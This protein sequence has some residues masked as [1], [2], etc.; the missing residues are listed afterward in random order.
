[1]GTE[2]TIVAA[3]CAA[4]VLAMAGTMSF[5]AL[6]PTFITEWQLSHSE[7]GWISGI[8]YGAYVAGVPILVSLTDR[9]DARRIVIVFSLLAAVSNIGFALFAEGF[10]SALFFR[11]LGGLALGGTYMPGLKALTD[12]VEGPYKARYQSFYT[13]SFSVG[14]SASLFI[15][16]VLAAQYDWPLAFVVAGVAPLLAVVVLLRWVPPVAPAP[17]EEKPEALLD[18]RPVLRQRESMSYVL[19]YAAHC[20]ELFAFRTWLVAFMTFNAVAHGSAI[21]ES[22]IATAAS[23]ILLLGLPASVLGNEVAT[24]LGRRGVLIGF[25]LASTLVASMIGFAA[26]LPFWWMTVLLAVYGVTVM[27]DSASLTIGALGAAA[28]ERRG[29]T[30]AV[31]TTLGTSMAFLGP[32]ASGFALDLTGGGATVLSWVTCFLVLAAGVALG[33]LALWGLGGR[34]APLSRQRETA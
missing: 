11:G 8:T 18:F 10:W 17:R 33:P 14:S 19:G 9:I 12:R 26:A 3:L 24:R 4:E 7:V 31:H 29:S 13:A 20:W 16:G 27:L 1:M 5:Q 22:T 21:G 2:R 28:P 15:T 32:L 30:L 6:I 34:G 23:L 25:M